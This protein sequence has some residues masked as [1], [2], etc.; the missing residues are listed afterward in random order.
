MN[1]SKDKIFYYKFSL[2]GGITV[3]PNLVVT[4]SLFVLFF[5]CFLKCEIIDLEKREKLDK[6]SSSNLN[7]M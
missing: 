1:K 6:F 7:N 2:V 3:L 4:F 5:L